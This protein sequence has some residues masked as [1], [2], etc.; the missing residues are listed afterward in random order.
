VISLR[1]VFYVNG[2]LLTTLAAAMVFTSVADIVVGNP[3][4]QVFV[5][6]AGVTIF[7]GVAL[8]L[9]S[10]G[11]WHRISIRQAF[12]LTASSWL[13]LAAFGA[14]PFAFSGLQLSYTDAFFESMSG[15]TTTGSTVI[16]GLD[17]APPGILLWRAFLQW[18]G[19]IGIIVVTV[20]ILP[21]LHVGG[22]QI[23]RMESSDRSDKVMPRAAQIAGGIALVYLGFSVLC[24]LAYWAA[25]MTTFEAIA[26]AMTT[27]ATG[28]FSTSDSSIGKFDSATIDW[29]A[30]L[31]MIIGAMPFV[32]YLQAVRG[33]PGLLIR[34][35]QVHWFL[36]IVLIAIIA[37]TLWLWVEFETEP[38]SALR[39]SAFNVVSIITGTGYST[40]AYDLWGGFALATFFLL[41]FIGG[42]AGSTS[43]GI[44]IFRFQVL[45][46][47]VR[48][49]VARLL[50]PHRVYI[51]YFN[52][53]PIPEDV[54]TSVMGFFF[55]FICAFAW[56]AM[57]LGLCGLDFLTAVSGAATAIA[58]VGPG[59]G[60]T[61][62]P[63]GTFAPIPDAA[64]WIMAAGMLLGRLELF[65]ILI[66]F[67]PSFWRD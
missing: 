52:R 29:I 44:K 56:I 33:K 61:I 3:D 14:L 63:A 12:L 54:S 41:M 15:L 46:E 65:T 5:A 8:I 51:P 64:K 36:S 1:P 45:Y 39:Y 10:S 58:N 22:M 35:T 38:G 34:D 31:F 37:L 18:L 55:L 50:E 48:V 24:S 59:L 11:K 60:P 13:V 30:T 4:W 9:T 42:C 2:V 62:G 27:I 57:L 16:V 6:S 17:S 43:C 53:V 23:F 40:T 49:Q 67:V 25:G 32:L 66:L 47:T 20:A 28:G 26:H 21:M 19:G 7:V